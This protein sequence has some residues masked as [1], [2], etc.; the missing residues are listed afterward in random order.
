MILILTDK[1]D[2]H[3]DVIIDKLIIKKQKYFRLNLDVESLLKTEISFSND[4]W[5][6]YQN[7]NRIYS[8]DIK[9]IY[10][11]TTFVKLSL[12]EENQNSVDFKIWKNEWNKT[13]LGFYNSIRNL[14]WFIPL[15]EA[16]RA[17]NKYYQFEIANKLGFNLP[18]T[19]VSN[20]KSKLIKFLRSNQNVIIKFMNQDF[21]K[22]ENKFKGIYVNKISLQDLD[23][24]KLSSENPIMLQTY[25]EKK[26]E[27]RYFVIGNKHLISKI[28]SQKS[29]IANVDWRRYD[30]PNTPHY[31]MEAPNDIKE[32]VTNLMKDLELNYG[33][34]DFIVDKNDN[35]YF[36]EINSMGQFLW[37]EDLTNLPIS[38]EIVNWLI[39]AKL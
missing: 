16:Y 31:P 39:Q 38:D 35:W 5:E 14:K 29:K 4:E 8:K 15:K 28:D 36:L 25:I 37:I 20:N 21:Y 10:P 27:V 12:E 6:I 9:V 13:L 17:E 3:S 34:L 22:V 18:K 24:F 26:F 2:V 11:R 30:L 1:D 33:A 23:D 19:I 7:Q 32:K